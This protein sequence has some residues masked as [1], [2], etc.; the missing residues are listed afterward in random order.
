M[1]CFTVGDFRKMADQLSIC[2]DE[3]ELRIFPN[4]FGTITDSVDLEFCE[5][6]LQHKYGDPED[7]F[8]VSMYATLIKQDTY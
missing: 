4:N 3:M 5:S 7:Q 8:V 2:P 1:N 6:P